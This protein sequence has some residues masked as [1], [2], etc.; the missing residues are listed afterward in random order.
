MSTQAKSGSTTAGSLGFA[1]RRK[2][3]RSE[4]SSICQSGLLNQFVEPLTYQRGFLE[5][6]GDT[7]VLHD[8]QIAEVVARSRYVR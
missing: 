4:C 1:R 7:S 6:Q 8:G 2:A 5:D 3:V